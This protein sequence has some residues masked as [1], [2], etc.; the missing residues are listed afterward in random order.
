[1][2]IR[3]IDIP[4]VTPGELPGVAVPAGTSGEN[5]GEALKGLGDATQKLGFL[6]YEQEVERARRREVLKLEQEL[7]GYYVSLHDPKEGLFAQNA[8][9]GAYK[10]ID[11]ALAEFDKRLEKRVGQY[12]DPVTEQRARSSAAGIRAKVLQAATLYADKEVTQASKQA[13]VDRAKKAAD[14][15]TVDLQNQGK[16]GLSGDTQ[17]TLYGMR[18]NVWHALSIDFGGVSYAADGEIV[19]NAAMSDKDRE[20]IE[21]QALQNTTAAVVTSIDVLRKRDG[22]DRRDL[23]TK[24]D[25]GIAKGFVAKGDKSV[26]DLRTILMKEIEDND[27]VAEAMRIV[28]TAAKQA[29][30]DPEMIAALASKMLFDKQDDAVM[31][32]PSKAD[33]WKKVGEA[34]NT[35]TAYRTHGAKALDTVR[36]DQV[37]RDLITRTHNGQMY[38][39]L[40]EFRKNAPNY[41]V[42]SVG[43][44]RS[45]DEL[46]QLKNK[47]SGLTS[48][49]VRELVEAEFYAA[50][51]SGVV[52]PDDMYSVIDQ[53]RMRRSKASG[54]WDEDAARKW[55][56]MV[57]S[58]AGEGTLAAAWSAARDVRFADWYHRAIVDKG[59]VLN[60]VVINLVRS[61][62]KLDPR[63]KDLLAARVHIAAYTKMVSQNKKGIEVADIAVIAADEA[64]KMGEALGA[65]WFSVFSSKDETLKETAESLRL[66]TQVA[67][68][69]WQSPD[70]KTFVQ[71]EVADPQ[72]PQGAIDSYNALRVNM[73]QFS[74]ERA[75]GR[76]IVDAKGNVLLRI[77]PNPQ[78]RPPV[79]R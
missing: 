56:A 39:S 2:R 12:G 67:R 35:Q 71:D 20:I 44:K 14:A 41:A 48:T 59:G 32:D 19:P 52:D 57:A 62:P 40:D 36:L 17:R 8:G 76:K 18:A 33:Y 77:E 61:N 74:E 51:R 9:D 3:D 53:I 1:M 4:T 54:D 47:D 11:T 23:L 28:A 66:K 34:V 63:N 50:L 78:Y 64:N 24:L 42:L 72:N 5:V 13:E 65:K 75:A 31:K 45:A 15:L 46:Y 38:P 70:G 27:A 16:G 43:A 21:H 58:L 73:Q 55:D 68:Y 25:D 29:N 7:E 60:D 37:A 10:V 22:A 69:V 26:E 49:Q 6:M 79:L 30:N